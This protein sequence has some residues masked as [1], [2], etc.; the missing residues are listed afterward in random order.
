MFLSPLP[1]GVKETAAHV[2]LAGD[3]EQ[4]VKFSKT[5]VDKRR[6]ATSVTRRYIY[7]HLSHQKRQTCWKLSKSFGDSEKNKEH[8]TTLFNFKQTGEISKL[9]IDRRREGARQYIYIS[10][11]RQ[12]KSA[13]TYGGLVYYFATKRKPKN[14][15]LRSC[16]LSRKVRN[17]TR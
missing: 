13:Q 3:F 10:S 2:M 7:T 14:I 6:K 4:I 11:L 17:Q 15:E 8:A 5:V 9:R 1:F 16:I 12:R